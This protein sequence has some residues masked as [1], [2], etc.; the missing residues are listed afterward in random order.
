MAALKEQSCHNGQALSFCAIRPAAAGTNK[1]D[2]MPD[3]DTSEL[4]ECLKCFGK[5]PINHAAFVDLIHKIVRELNL[6]GKIV[7]IKVKGPMLSRAQLYRERENPW[8]SPYVVLDLYLDRYLEENL[9]RHEFG[10]EADRHDPTMGYDPEVEIRWR[11]LPCVFDLAANI[12]LDSRLAPRG[13]SK[14]K[15]IAEFQDVLGFSD[16]V[17]FEKLWAN[18][19]RTWA[20]ISELARLFEQRRIVKNAPD[21]C[22]R[23][24]RHGTVDR[25][26]RL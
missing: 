13:L 12:S 5:P 19:P 16:D 20:A 8:P 9:I 11:R 1:Q 21:R 4:G 25:L 26:D 17:W 7:G 2:S 6:R 18:P 24:T 3:V 15:R 14:A 23:R 22:E 10:H